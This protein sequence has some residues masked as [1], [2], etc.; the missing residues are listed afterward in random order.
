MGAAEPALL[1]LKGPAANLLLTGPAPPLLL[2]Y[3]Q[4]ANQS[5]TDIEKDD[6]SDG[7]RT[8]K[9]RRNRKNKKMKDAIE[10]QLKWM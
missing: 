6:E 8:N 7:N 1:R 2:T 5:L 9:S 3:K 4:I 10:S